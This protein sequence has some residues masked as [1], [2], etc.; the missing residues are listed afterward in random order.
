MNNLRSRTIQE[1]AINDNKK[2]LSTSNKNINANTESNKFMYKCSKMNNNERNVFDI[3]FQCPAKIR[4]CVPNSFNPNAIIVNI[5]SYQKHDSKNSSSAES[6]LPVFKKNPT[7]SKY[8][9]CTS[10]TSDH[11][12]KKSESKHSNQ[13]NAKSN[14]ERMLELD[15]FKTHLNTHIRKGKKKLI[16]N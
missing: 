15:V 12:I 8:S 9:L 5:C 6:Y 10:T 16:K 11:Q 7:L 3:F 1:P 13:R 4:T 2:H 14:N